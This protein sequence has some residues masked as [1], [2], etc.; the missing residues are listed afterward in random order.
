MKKDV[1][2]LKDGREGTLEGLEGRKEKEKCCNYFIISKIK[3]WMWRSR[4]KQIMGSKP[5]RSTQ[6][7]SG[8]HR[9]NLSQT[10]KVK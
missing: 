8:L 9:K 7:V 6:Q 4:R 1:L 5:A 2:N 3:S 10:T